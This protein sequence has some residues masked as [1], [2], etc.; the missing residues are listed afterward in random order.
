MSLSRRH[1]V[2][3]I[4]LVGVGSV[5]LF[6]ATACAQARTDWLWHG[7]LTPPDAAKPLPG[8]DWAGAKGILNADL[9]WIKHLGLTGAHCPDRPV[10]ARSASVNDRIVY[11]SLE[12]KA[13]FRYGTGLA[14]ACGVDVMI[15]TSPGY[16]HTGGPWVKPDQA[17]KKLVWS[18]T[19]I[20]GGRPFRGVLAPPPATVGPFQNSPYVRLYVEPASATITEQF[21]ADAAVI[22]YRVRVTE[23]P[24]RVTVT[25][26]SGPINAALLSDGDLLKSLELPADNG[27]AWVQ[28]TYD[29]PRTIRSAVFGTPFVRDAVDGNMLPTM[30]A[31]LE[32]QDEDGVYRTVATMTVGNVPEVTA[33]FSSVTAKV[34][35]V[36]LFWPPANH[37]SITVPPG[38]GEDNLLTT[39]Y[40]PP[41]QT[42][43]ISELSLQSEGRV[44][45]FE[46]KAGFAVTD[47]YYAIDTPAGAANAPVPK[48]DVVD[49]SAKMDAAGTLTWTPPS[50][51]WAVL[52]LG[53]SLVGKLNHP[54]PPEATG[55]EV[56]KLNR[57]F[58]QDYMKTYL[59]SYARFL[60]PS[61][62]G[63]HG[64][65][66]VFSDSI[67][68]GPQN[69]TNDMLEQFQHLRGYDP[70][71]WLPALTG[72]IVQSA[73]A[74][75]KFLWDFR[76]TIAQLLAQNH[77]A[78]VATATHAH[79]LRQ[80]GEALEFGRP[81]LG[82][83]MEMRRYSDVPMGA[84]WNF[85]PDK[86]PFPPYV[87]DERGAASVAHV[88]GQNMAAGESF[89]EI[90]EPFAF[91]PRNLKPIA[92][93]EFGL[94]INRLIGIGVDRA[95]TWAKDAGPWVSYLARSSY[96]LQ[97]GHFVADVAY[98]YGEEAPLTVLQ[99]LGR[100][101]D[102][103]K[104]YAFDF[105]NAD[106]LLNLLDVQNGYL[107]TPSGMHYRALQLGGT[108]SRM[109][110]PALR[111]V[112]DLV[113]K[114]AVVVG[115]PPVESPSLADDEKEFRAIVDSL[116]GD[117]SE[118]EHSVGKGKIFAGDN[119][120]ATLAA[121]GM[122]PD[123]GYSSPDSDRHVAF[124]HR[125]LG[126]GDLYFV[127][128]RSD[129]DETIDATFRVAGKAPELWH[130][131]TG[132]REPTSYAVQDART[133]VPL[134]LEPWGA[135]FV[136]FRAPAKSNS[137][138][139]PKVEE[140]RLATLDSPWQVSFQKD[141]GAPSTVTLDRLASWTESTN[142]GVK[143]FSG[144]A[145]YTQTVKAL[146]DWFNPRT[147]LW[148]DLGDV[149]E[150]AEV[151][152][153]GKDLGI[154]WH[155]PYKVDVTGV[156]HSGRNTIRV[157]VTNLWVNR[158][159]GDAQPGGTG[160]YASSV[161]HPLTFTEAKATHHV[162]KPDA[163]VRLSGLLGP[164]VVV[165]SKNVRTN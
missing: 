117:G 67:E 37:L 13:A 91:S 68:T 3:W 50:G 160:Q 33:S 162:Y 97:Q 164:V 136:V 71:P 59:D 63:A 92:D 157:K 100:L 16:S 29:R 126:D 130:A 146:A 90:F 27:T 11:M 163:P 128:N 30:A 32:A 75:D 108:S 25:S 4:W 8:I 26:R 149:R 61:L 12:W 40:P 125:K 18:T 147:R 98:F 31:R 41:P 122:P 42:F 74:S 101:Q 34:F 165:G 127:N 7:F 132:K 78:E 121:L 77:Y 110:L 5:F 6:A 129:R 20:Q 53:Y 102:K 72:V 140:T 150:L 35:R 57:D 154:L 139:L 44:N 49:L 134:H 14:D 2:V 64:L 158:M 55:L 56:D 119:V 84:M 39:G 135:V 15:D 48:S 106:A 65:R 70:R 17:M 141:R 58:V 93:L 23:A 88:Y 138:I 112:R 69:W 82:D 79:G 99:N 151:I 115:V 152:V 80:Y 66:I 124:V 118:G 86:G 133:T 107:T 114:G 1:F 94:G 156:L 155:R 9:R 52:R 153:N 143:Y 111:K 62:M 148:I 81:M 19:L 21:Y 123:F 104:E 46:R 85:R 54:A 159:V 43:A 10:G 28:F 87:D 103:P 144:S 131:E 145:T 109:T 96:L 137:V 38:I 95:N 24:V 45:E 89:T 22:A 73:T 113:Q 51:Q 116:W 120:D 36:V 76:R 105:I 161:D 83:D 60:S 142:Q 47:D